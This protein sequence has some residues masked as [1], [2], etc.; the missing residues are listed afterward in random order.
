MITLIYMAVTSG[1]AGG[2][3]YGHKMFKYTW[4][5]EV[6]FSLPFVIALYPLIGIPALLAWPWS[7]IFMQS[8][9]WII[10]PWGTEPLPEDR[11][12]TLKPI[13]DWFAEKR[14]VEFGSVNYARIY[15]AIK[16]FLITLPVGGTGA[17]FWTLGHEIGA[18]F[19]NHLLRELLSGAG[20]GVS[21]LLFWRILSV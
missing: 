18:K 11:Q 13:A 21:I 17:I 1:W 9:T 16:G 12:A 4:M 3:L 19:N 7:Y 14:N 10:L 8:G 5:P 20:A 15:A 2:S 6:L